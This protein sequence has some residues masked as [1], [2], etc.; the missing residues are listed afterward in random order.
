MPVAK[1]A[2]IADEFQDGLLIGNGASVS[3]HEGF[4]YNNLWQKAVNDGL[5]SSELQRIAAD[6][7][8]GCNFELVMRQLWIASLVNEKFDING[9]KIHES[10]DQIRD[11]LIN[12][13]RDIHCSFND[14]LD[15]LTSIGQFCRGFKTVLS[16][17]YDFLPYWAFQRSNAQQHSHRFKDCFNA[18]VFAEK[19]HEYRKPIG[20]QEACTLYFYPHGALHLVNCPEG[21]QKLNALGDG[22]GLIDV[23]VDSWRDDE[24]LPLFVSEG[25]NNAK[26]RE[27]KRRD[28][29]SRV[30]Y[31]VIP[32]SVE[33]LAVYGWSLSKEDN[34]LLKKIGGGNCKK[35]AISIHNPSMKD[36][37]GFMSEKKKLLKS[38][39]IEDVTFFDSESDGCWVY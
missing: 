16:L 39:G 1:W 34:H 10:Y 19:W 29:L 15:A 4:N 21:E 17:N 38:Y 9:A 13:V 32:E 5:M 26:L 20:Q 6:L 23:V 11:A 12:V 22:D 14:V 3:V 33:T 37:T 30:Y 8:L 35:I 24:C 2:E 25:D 27:I 31:E 36:V 7:E 18:G 28:Y